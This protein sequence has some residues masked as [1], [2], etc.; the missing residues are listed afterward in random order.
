MSLKAGSSEKVVLKTCVR[1]FL[2]VTKME[3]KIIVDHLGNRAEIS[4]EMKGR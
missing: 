3:L 2:L 1:T 4:T